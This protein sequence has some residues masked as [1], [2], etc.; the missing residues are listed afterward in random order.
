L[1]LKIETSEDSQFKTLFAAFEITFILTDEGVKE[2]RT[3]VAALGKYIELLQV[4][5]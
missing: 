3:V 1:I 4:S 2:W 5:F